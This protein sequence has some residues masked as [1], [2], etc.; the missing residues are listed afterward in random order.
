MISVLFETHHLY[1]LPQFEPVI[2]ELQRR[3]GYEICISMPRSVDLWEQNYL[4]QA[5]SELGTEYVTSRTEESRVS[6]LRSRDFDVVVI[7]NV[8][9]LE[10][11][12]TE[13]SLAVMVYHGIGLKWSYYR[14]VTPRI[15]IRAVESEPRFTLLRKEGAHN[16][17]LTGFTKLDP[18]ITGLGIETD[19]LLGK[20]GLNPARKTVLY[21]PTFYP[22]SLEKLLPELPRLAQQVNVVVKLHNFSWYK[23]RFSHQSRKARKVAAGEQNVFLVPREEFNILPYYASAHVMISDI[24]STLFEYLV[25]N[26][27]IIQTDFYALRLKHR[28]FPSRLTRK[29]D[30]PRA[31]EVDFT[32]RMSDP[33]GVHS[34]V[35]H[36]L[37]HPH[38]LQERR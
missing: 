9:R 13:S 28:L 6:D 15:D 3:G 33:K 30:L 35:A 8:G 36:T 4:A 11:V 7:G 37:S 2:R 1:Y 27:P 32:H 23:E 22:S 29:L 18:L 21:A 12:V 24:S 31:E 26:R 25:L 5:A 16:L 19:S 14:D 38:E 34:L 20:C 17:A 10:D